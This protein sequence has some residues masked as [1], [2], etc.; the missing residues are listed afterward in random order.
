MNNYKLYHLG[1][2]EIK[3]K[4]TQFAEPDLDGKVSCLVRSVPYP[5]QILWVRDN[6]IIDYAQSGRYSITQTQMADGVENIL[7]ISH[8]TP[9]DFGQYICTVFNGYGNDT[10]TI[11]LAETGQ[12]RWRHFMTVENILL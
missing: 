6:K 9:S 1:P 4:A 11:T 10:M 5:D 2:P 12:F 7:H 8:L 3:S